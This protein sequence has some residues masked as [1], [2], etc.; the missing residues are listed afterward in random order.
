MSTPGPKVIPEAVKMP[1]KKSV[2]SDRLEDYSWLIF[3]KKKIG[4]TTLIAQFENVFL[5]PTEPGSKAISVYQPT[6]KKGNP[7]V[8]DSWPLFCGYV[9][10]YLEDTETYGP[11][12]VDII[13]KAYELAFDHTCHVLGIEH[14]ND[15][16]DYGKSWQAI[17]KECM[18]VVKKL[19]ADRRG[20][21]LL[22]HVKQREVEN[23]LTGEVSEKLFCSLSGRIHEEITGIVDVWAYY[24]YHKTERRLWINGHED[25]DCGTRIENRFL[26]SE[27]GKQLSY[28]PMGDSPAESKENL[29]KAFENEISTAKRDHVPK[30]GG[31][32]LKKRKVNK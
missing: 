11:S 31:V 24:G 13:D 26:D 14:P 8:L 12:C 10:G 19:L 1:T 15:E 5:F 17:N 28:I 25:I 3:G 9:D 6:D 2:I 27:T 4:K 18:R 22:S 20:C 21:F 7:R 32:K 30:K 23:P 29:L 16:K